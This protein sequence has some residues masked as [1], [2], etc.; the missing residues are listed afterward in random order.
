VFVLALFLGGVWFFRHLQSV[1][2]VGGR[3]RKLN[4]LEVRPLGGRQAIY[5]VGYADQRML[6]SS[7]AS[8][9]QYLRDLPDEAEPAPEAP[10]AETKPEGNPGLAACFKTALAKQ[11]Q[12]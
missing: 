7:S 11:M 12:G 4:I 8:G 6:V 1:N 5:V 2:M 9:V 10:P 3:A